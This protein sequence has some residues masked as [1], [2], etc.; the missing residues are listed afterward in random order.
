MPQRPLQ[1]WLHLHLAEFFDGEV[2]VLEGFFLFFRVVFKQKLGKTK[3]GEGYFGAEPE[4]GGNPQSF[5]VVSASFFV[6]GR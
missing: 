1:G 5:P 2:Q 3:A 6:L 4:L